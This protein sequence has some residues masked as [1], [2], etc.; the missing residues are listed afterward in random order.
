MCYSIESKDRIYLKDCGCLYFAKNISKRL[1]NKCSHNLLDRAE[2]S[3]T[4]AI[5]TTSK[6]AI[7]KKKK[8]E[9]TGDLIGNKIAGSITKVPK[10]PQNNSKAVKRE[11]DMSKERYISPEKG[12]QII[13]KIKTRNK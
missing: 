3:T 12:Q 2:K 9:A 7:Q 6:T 1:S 13:N 11:E 8:T 10:T 4:D 5:K